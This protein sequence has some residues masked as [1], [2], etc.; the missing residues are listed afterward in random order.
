METN[1]IPS[2]GQFKFAVTKGNFPNHVIKALGERGNWKQVMEEDQA[3]ET[4]DFF[5]R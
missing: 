2:E 3:I 4:T 5:W 1:N